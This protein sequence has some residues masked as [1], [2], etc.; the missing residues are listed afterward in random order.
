MRSAAEDLGLSIR[1]LPAAP[2]VKTHPVRAPRIALVHTW[3]STQDEGWWRLAFDELKIPYEYISTQT[4]A[5]TADL[6]ARFDVLLFP[7]VGPRRPGDRAGMPMWG[8]PL[9]WKV[10]P[11]TPN[12]GKTDTTDDMR[13]GLGWQ[14]LQNLR[15]F[16]RRGG[17]LIGCEDTAELA[18]SFGLTQGVSTARPEKLKVTGAVVKAKLVDAGSPI[19]YGYGDTALDLRLRRP[20]LQPLQPR[21]IYSPPPARRRRTGARHGPRHRGGSGPARSADSSSRPPKSPRPSPGRRC[22]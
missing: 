19:A 3:L 20:D 10:T 12:L 18:I 7:P 5:R 1:A 17:L 13:P 6:S 11:L 15:E 16:V 2:S 14:G 4:V 21:R 8:N 22:P 9:P